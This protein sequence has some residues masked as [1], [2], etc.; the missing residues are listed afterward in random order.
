MGTFDEWIALWRQYYRS[1]G[2]TPQF[3][4]F[5]SMKCYNP[6]SLQSVF[7]SCT[8]NADGVGLL[9]THHVSSAVAHRSMNAAFFVGLQEAYQESVC[10]L[11]AKMTN[12]LPKGC[13]CNGSTG[14]NTEFV[15]CAKKRVPLKRYNATVLQWVDEITAA[16]CELYRAVRERF[17][18]EVRWV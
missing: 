7:F 12:A 10:V 11:V 17:L 9:D 18:R 1:R 2:Q 15:N 14:L 5:V 4:T 3:G 13:R 16:D 6:I 8:S